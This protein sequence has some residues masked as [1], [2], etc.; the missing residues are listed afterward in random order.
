[1]LGTY[2][3]LQL[4]AMVV[5]VGG[6]IF[7][8]FVMAPTAFSVL[9]I[10][11]E[12]GLVVGAS[13]KRFDVLALVSGALFL[14]ATALLFRAAPMRIR[15][16]YEIEFLLAGAM[17]IATAYIHWNIEPSMERDRVAAGGDIE[18]AALTAPPR[19]HFET[20][21][22]RSEQMEVGV[23]LLGLAVLFLMSREQMGADALNL[24]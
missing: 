24:R 23:L 1:M 18:A 16:R 5:W 7:F 20:L 22:K 19:V 11:H 3:L 10:K 4:L 12:A 21:H 9:P 14:A 8:A 17:L 13:L 6:L 15:G 2:R